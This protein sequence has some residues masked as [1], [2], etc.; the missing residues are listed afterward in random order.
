MAGVTGYSV[1]VDIGRQYQA[2]VVMVMGAH[3]TATDS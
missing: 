3:R 2:Q 1:N